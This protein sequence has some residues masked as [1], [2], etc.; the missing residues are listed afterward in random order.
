MQE[1][2][3][4]YLPITTKLPQCV[5]VRHVARTPFSN[6]IGFNLWSPMRILLYDQVVAMYMPSWR[7]AM[8]SHC[9][10]LCMQELRLVIGGKTRLSF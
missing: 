9:L 7:E 2:K 5:T 6:S 1:V 10:S 4:S 8:L 3:T